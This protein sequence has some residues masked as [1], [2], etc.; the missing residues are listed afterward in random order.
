[1]TEQLRVI[2]LSGNA[3]FHS[4]ARFCHHVA[5]R[6]TNVQNVKVASSGVFAVH[7]PV[8]GVGD[9][10]AAGGGDADS[11]AGVDGAAASTTRAA[12]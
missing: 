3:A 12:S 11:P 4:S 9:A 5:W 2:F 1:M 8:F 10:S 6:S 7:S